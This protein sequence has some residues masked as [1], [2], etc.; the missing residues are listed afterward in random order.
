MKRIIISSI[1]ILFFAAEMFGQIGYGEYRN[2]RTEKVGKNKNSVYEQI[3]NLT[4]QGLNNADY[5]DIYAGMA[6]DRDMLKP[7]VLELFLNKNDI[8]VTGEFARFVSKNSSKVM[9]ISNMDEAEYS[10]L[11]SR[12][13]D[14]EFD[15]ICE[16]RSESDNFESS[17]Y[18]S[19]IND[20]VRYI[21]A[22]NGN[23]DPEL[24]R[25]EYMT[26]YYYKTKQA[27]KLADYAPRFADAII[28]QGEND[29]P[30]IY[31]S[32]SNANS[33]NE[34]YAMKLSSAAQFIVETLSHKQTLNN[35]L[36]W[37]I[38]AVEL[39]GNSSNYETQA[40][41]LYK[42]GKRNEAI[43]CMEKAYTLAPGFEELGEISM[44]L[45]K[46]K[47]GERIF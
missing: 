8:N 46:M 5:I 3:V 35:A 31:M 40:Y 9:A 16:S 2:N 21:A 43:V 29:S 39:S 19:K 28:R 34:I 27:L 23:V 38:K 6:H 15:R 17:I 24:L 42:L 22:N 36:T 32:A 41:L 18:E 30:K 13:A 4:K 14:R 47:R 37:S 25:A 45:V 44:R 1:I 11:F 20:L 26:R 7:N 33:N 10:A 12:F